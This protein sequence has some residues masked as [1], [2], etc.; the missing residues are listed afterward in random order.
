LE[1]KEIDLFFSSSLSH[2]L[3]CGAE[4]EKRRKNQSTADV[5]LKRSVSLDFPREAVSLSLSL[6]S[7]SLGIEHAEGKS[8][9]WFWD[10]API[11]VLTIR[12]D[13]GGKGEKRR[14]LRVSRER[15]D[16]RGGS[17]R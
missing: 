13:R 16:E 9:I 10:F 2:S 1:K 5:S 17:S 7:L 14:A 6:F 15:D 8:T 11:R 12:E 3:T 4:R